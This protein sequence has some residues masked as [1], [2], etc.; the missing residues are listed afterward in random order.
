MTRKASVNGC[1][2][3]WRALSIHS[4][5][6]STIPRFGVVI[7]LPRN[8]VYPKQSAY[9]TNL[10]TKEVNMQQPMHVVD[11]RAISYATVADFF[12]TFTDEMHSLN[13]LSLLLTADKDKAEECFVCAMGEC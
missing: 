2:T 12:K 10:G 5:S 3:T 4:A 1:P 11:E 9:W 8:V 7:L 6:V 13:V